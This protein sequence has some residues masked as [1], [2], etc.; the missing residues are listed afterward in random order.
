MGQDRAIARWVLIGVV[1]V[2]AI[3]LAVMPST[4]GQL[5]G[6]VID[7]EGDLTEVQSFEVLS[8]GERFI[9]EP[10]RDGEFAFPLPHLREHLRTGEPVA[11]EYER[12][13]GVLMAMRV[14]DAD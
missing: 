8:D 12:I 14:S 13:D 9:F 1:A 10:A 3:T 11:I 4:S 2:G 7:V 5:S 6:I